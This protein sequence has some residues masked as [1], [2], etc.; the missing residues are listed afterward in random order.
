VEAAAAATAAA[1][2]VVVVVVVLVVV[3]VV[4]VVVVI[5]VYRYDTCFSHLRENRDYRI[6]VRLPVN[7]AVGRISVHKKADRKHPTVNLFVPFSLILL[8][9]YKACKTGWAEYVAR[10]GRKACDILMGNQKWN[11]IQYQWEVLL[12]IKGK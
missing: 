8:R 1:A 11:R 12:L 3:V 2:V 4:V 7:E 10:M 5:V 9:R 6:E